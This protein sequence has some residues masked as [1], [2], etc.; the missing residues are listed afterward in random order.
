MSFDL[1]R[2]R[3]S[4]TASAVGVR[5]EYREQTGSTM[6]DARALLAAEPDL[7]VGTAC[8]AG[9]QLMG[10]GRLR[11]HW[12]SALDLGLYV[13]YY[14][15]PEVSPDA[16]LI[17]LAAALAVAEAVRTVCGAEVV[18]KWP[19]DVLYEGR[20]LCGILAE[21][22]STGDRLDVFLGIGVNVRPNPNHPPEVAALAL[23]LEEIV[24]MA[25]A[26]EDLA[27]AL[28]NSLEQHVGHVDHDPDRVVGEW[29]A[30]LGTLGQRVTITTASGA[31]TGEAV[32]VGSRGELIIEGKDGERREFSAGDV[33]IPGSSG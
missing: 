28:S 32:N 13:T 20:K 12:V 5:V 9:E 26:I 27:A 18:F 16:P 23:S 25:P 10:R 3:A 8:I 17:S 24:G 14:L 1:E 31:F 15:R 22:R 6:D 29:Q 19:N 11:R 4:L 7:E 2:Y 33:V 30:N 21:A